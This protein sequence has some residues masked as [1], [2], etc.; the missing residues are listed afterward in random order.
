MAK[1]STER[2]IKKNQDKTHDAIQ[3]KIES[4]YKLGKEFYVDAYG[5]GVVPEK[6]WQQA[7]KDGRP[8]GIA[9]YV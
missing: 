2:Q 5:P 8:E 6:K 7:K 1:R 3:K 9:D 4:Q